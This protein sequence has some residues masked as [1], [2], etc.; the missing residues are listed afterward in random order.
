MRQ[1]YIRLD[2][3]SNLTNVGT[4]KLLTKHGNSM[5]MVIE[6]PILKLIG[7]DADTPFEITT[8]SQALIPV[9][10]SD[11]CVNNHRFLSL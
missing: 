10:C 8:D 6:K 11:K 1:Y 9:V 4:I 3:H 2:D 5:A 7:A